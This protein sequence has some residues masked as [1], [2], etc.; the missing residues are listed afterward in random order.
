MRTKTE[1]KVMLRN[2]KHLSQRRK[3]NSTPIDSKKRRS[4]K[5]YLHYLFQRKCQQKWTGEV[6]IIIDRF[7]HVHLP[8]YNL[9]DFNWEN[10]SGTL[11]T[12]ELQQVNKSGNTVWKINTIMKRRNVGGEKQV[13]VSWQYWTFNSWIK[14]SD[15]ESI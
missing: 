13:F 8:V 7:M 11:Y 14:E 5:N 6:F 12:S 4:R 9:K 10:V 1:L 3:N 15:M 2:K